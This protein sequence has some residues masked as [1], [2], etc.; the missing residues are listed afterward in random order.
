MTILSGYCMMNW[1]IKN[2]K[3]VILVL[4]LFLGIGLSSLGRYV[5]AY[6]MSSPNYRIQSD[7]LNI[8]GMRETST[9]YRMEDTIGEIATG[10][11]TSTSYKLKAGYQQMQ[12]TY[13]AISSPSDVTMSP[14][15]SGVTGGT[16]NG[17][18]VWAVTTDNPAGY[19]L[20]IKAGASPALQS[21]AYSFADYTPTVAGTPDFNWEVAST[22]AEFGFTPE[23]SDIV[24]KFKDNSLDT[25]N[26]GTT[27]TTDACWYNFSTSNEIIAQ[28]S[29]PN[30]P[31]GTSTTVKFRAE[32]GSEHLQPAGTYQANIIVTALAL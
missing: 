15:I 14:A 8:G 30:H 18:A 7:S 26:I 24:Q 1:S 3:I 10:V 20:A 16:G 2:K 22:D 17:S 12:E 9:S 13:L 6:V 23:G 4:S 19:S 5:F 27:D 21:G 28:S 25:C 32:S 31:S 11:L 29:S